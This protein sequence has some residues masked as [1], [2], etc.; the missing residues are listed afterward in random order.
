MYIIYA[1]RG[2][3]ITV[4]AITFVGGLL[5]GASFSQATVRSPKK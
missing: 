4:A 1:L 3:P 2:V 5:M